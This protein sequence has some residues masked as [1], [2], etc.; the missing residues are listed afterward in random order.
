MKTFSNKLIF[1]VF[2]TFLLTSC[3]VEWFIRMPTKN[4]SVTADYPSNK[5]GLVIVRTLSPVIIGW[6]YYSLEDNRQ[7]K[8]SDVDIMSMTWGPGNYQVLMLDPGIYSVSYFRDAYIAYSNPIVFKGETLSSDG[9]PTIGAFEVKS[10]V[11]SY[12]GDLEFRDFTNLNVK[13][14]FEAA[15]LFF[16]KNYPKINSP[17]IKNL[18]YNK[19]GKTHE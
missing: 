17:I 18:A 11:I 16:R 6:K 8:K 5:K 4:T 13:D 19:S 9:V 14:D 10:E 7:Y 12:V 1:L 15:K 3:S 2:I